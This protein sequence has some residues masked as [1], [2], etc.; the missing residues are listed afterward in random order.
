MITKE[1]FPTLP[2]RELNHNQHL[3]SKIDRLIEL[4]SQVDNDSF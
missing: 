2:N 3:A 4:L 1:K